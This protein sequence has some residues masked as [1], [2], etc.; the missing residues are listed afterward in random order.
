MPFFVEGLIRFVILD[1]SFNLHTFSSTTLA[2]SIALLCL[3]LNQNLL[4]H[5]ISPNKDE[6]EQSRLYGTATWFLTFAMISVILF[7][8][9]V[10]LIAINEEHNNIVKK[11]VYIFEYTVFIFCLFPIVIAIL[12]QRSYKLKAVI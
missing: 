3:F 12:T 2:A 10:T 8:V 11:A 4:A 1:R 7:A 6:Y 9:I 5:N